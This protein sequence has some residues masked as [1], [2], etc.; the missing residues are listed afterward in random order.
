MTRHPGGVIARSRSMVPLDARIEDRPVAFIDS[1]TLLLIILAGAVSAGL[2]V[3]LLRN[4]DR[5]KMLT[6]RVK[7]NGFSNVP[8]TMRPTASARQIWKSKRE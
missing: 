4:L 1:N 8:S 6:P 2:T 5:R 3:Y 7:P